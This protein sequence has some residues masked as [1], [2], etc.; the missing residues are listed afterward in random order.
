MTLKTKIFILLI[1][2]LL[3]SQQKTK[4]N[5][6][7]L[8]LIHQS[9]P[10]E[11]WNF[12]KMS[13]LDKEYYVNLTHANPFYYHGDFDGDKKTD[14]AVIL[15]KRKNEQSR[16]AILGGN[17]R[18]YWLDNNDSLSYPAFNAWYVLPEGEAVEQGFEENL[19]PPKL[20]GDGLMVF[21]VE[22]SSALIYWNGKKFVS[23]WEGD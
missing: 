3:F 2:I 18:I 1:P 10:P 22:A 12:F 7:N 19:H 8:F 6:Y 5:E 13:G 20:L 4:E 11:L 16:L 17:K 21:S 9:A 23:Y 14:Y 15:T